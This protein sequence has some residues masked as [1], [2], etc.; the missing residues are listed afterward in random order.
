MKILRLA[1]NIAALFIL[2]VA[3]LASQPGVGLLHAANH[4]SCGYKPGKG[5]VSDG[6]NCYESNCGGK[7][8][9]PCPNSGCI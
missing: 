9:F 2:G 4:K 7:S 6:V 1:R 5:C 8:G 3:L